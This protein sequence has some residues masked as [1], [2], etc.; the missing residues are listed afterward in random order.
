MAIGHPDDFVRFELD[1]STETASSDHILPSSSGRQ[2]HRATRA[3]VRSGAR[4]GQ[5]CLKGV[6]RAFPLRSTWA[7]PP[8]DLIPITPKAVP[9]LVGLK[10]TVKVWLAPA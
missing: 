5:G 10:R 2:K 4:L 9:L 8:P 6:R 3:N 7:L 1:S